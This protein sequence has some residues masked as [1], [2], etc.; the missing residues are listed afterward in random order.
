MNGDFSLNEDALAF[1]RTA[2]QKLA[3]LSS[4][5]WFE[6]VPRSHNKHVDGLATLASKPE[7]MD[8]IAEN[9]SDHKYTSSYSDRP[10]P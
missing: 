6:H 5:I 7:I 1:Y 8:D 10:H 3:K 4:S 9:A 2:V